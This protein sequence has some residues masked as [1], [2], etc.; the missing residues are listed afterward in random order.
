MNLLP[1]NLGP[2][3]DLTSEAGK[4]ALSGVRIEFKD[5]KYEAEA[6]DAKILATIEG[7]CEDPKDYPA[8]PALELAPNGKS[9][10]LVPAAL[11][12][13]A[14]ATAK[15][16]TKAR[17]M[18]P[19]LKNNAIKIGEY[20]VT[21]AATDLEKSP[22]TSGKQLEGRYPPTKE[23]YPKSDHKKM[24]KLRLKSEDLIRLVKASQIVDEVVTV[25]IFHGSYN[26]VLMEAEST[27]QK[28]K[29]LIFPASIR[30]FD[31][32]EKLQQVMD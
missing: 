5:D 28:F 4:F 18:K 16:V 26:C 7:V 25:T 24:V 6:T 10:C 30:K 17:H 14:F 2:L 20:D 8:I 21:F 3:A 29:G 1:V 15:K 19:I 23:V 32:E 12:R 22:V 9:V 31:A 11:W 13:D 27:S